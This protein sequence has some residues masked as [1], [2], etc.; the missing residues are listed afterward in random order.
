VE[1]FTLIELLV[2][3]TI[4]VVLLALL[5]PALD[6]AI[7]QAELASCG[8]KQ[9]VLAAASTVY[10]TG[11]RRWYPY[12]KMVFETPQS[13][14]NNIK[15]ENKKDET[16]VL[17]SFLSLSQNLN[18][19]LAKAVDLMANTPDTQIY[20]NVAYWAGWQ[21]I[22]ADHGGPGMRKLGDGW[23]WDQRRYTVI[24]SDRDCVMPTL[25]NFQSSHPDAD[26]VGYNLV[27]QNFQNPWTATDT[28]PWTYSIWTA[29]TRTSKR[30]LIDTNVA[31]ADGAVARYNR[32]PPDAYDDDRFGKVPCRSD[33]LGWPAQGE[34]NQWQNL[35]VN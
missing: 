35:P 17:S 21:F 2:V 16:P 32:V 34:P 15:R 14:P 29:D 19:P 11:Q 13:Q 1:G 24:T 22:N 12:R 26:G 5:T 33:G 3:I 31:Y 8:A 28:V 27:L 18:D 10:A 23:T 6:K 7:Y 30:G 4:I 9:G 25:N 20:S